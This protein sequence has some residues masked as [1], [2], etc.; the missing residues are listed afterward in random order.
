[1]IASAPNRTIRAQYRV[2]SFAKPLSVNPNG[3]FDRRN[4]IE[5]SRMSGK[6]TELMPVS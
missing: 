4:T 1:M 5:C 2:I 3:A 6:S